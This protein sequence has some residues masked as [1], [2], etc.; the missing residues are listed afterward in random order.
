MGMDSWTDQSHFHFREFLSVRFALSFA[1]CERSSCRLAWADSARFPFFLSSIVE[2]GKKWNSGHCMRS[3]P[4]A[5]LIASQTPIL[6]F[7]ARTRSR[8]SHGVFVFHNSCAALTS[9]L[10][11]FFCLILLQGC[12]KPIAT[13][14]Q[15]LASPFHQ[16]LPMCALII[17]ATYFP[18]L[19][20]FML[21][22][23]FAKYIFFNLAAYCSVASWYTADWPPTEYSG[24]ILATQDM[25]FC[26][27]L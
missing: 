14:T 26:K 19:S 9:L 16:Y 20:L 22:L 1:V 2:R 10:S 24:S 4:S 5:C 17:L 27:A 11:P 6:D 21:L 25:P 13:C 8:V 23:R 15:L 3:L 18:N 7:A 12:A